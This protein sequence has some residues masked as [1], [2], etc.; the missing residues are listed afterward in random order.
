MQEFIEITD[1]DLND[2]SAST[3]NMVGDVFNQLLKTTKAKLVYPSSSKLPQQFIDKLYIDFKVLLDE[4]GDVRFKV[5]SDGILY[6]NQPV[7]KAR[8]K[9]ENFAH[10]FF[11][12][13]ILELEFRKGITEEELEKFVDILTMIMR[14][15]LVD[16]DL[17]TLLWEAGFEHFSYKL[18]D[19]SIDLETFEYGTGAL[20]TSIDPSPEN[21]K[22]IF[23]TSQDLDFTEEDFD[24]ESEKNN[25][26]K[27]P[28]G[29]KSLVNNVAEYINRITEYS[30]SEKAAINDIL[31]SDNEFNYRNYI[32]DIMFELLGMEDDNAGYRETLDLIGKVRDDFIRSG[33]MRS[34]TVIFKRS[35]ELHEAIEHLND[36]KAK[37]LGEFIHK[38]GASEKIRVIVDMLNTSKDIEY[39]LISEYVKLFTWHA[40]DPLIWALG[41]LNHYPAR[42]AICQG[43]EVIAVDNVEMLGKGTEN[44]RWY[45]VRNVVSV[46]G[47][48]GSPKALS[49]FKRTITHSDIRVRK[50]TVVS[51]AKI[52]GDQAAAFLIEALKDEN[53]NLQTLAL[54][55]L[56]K[57]KANKAFDYLKVMISDKNFKNR[58]VEQIREILEGFARLGGQ[59]AFE[60]LK[61]QVTRKTLFPSEKQDRVRVYATRALGYISIP[62][63]IRLLD[64][65]SKSRNKSMADAAKRAL[66]R[67]TRG[68][69]FV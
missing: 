6:N 61:N 10:P 66:L 14:S 62:Q 15:A 30:E 37:R 18:M 43:L 33:D 4:L 67:R 60:Q 23:D 1:S 34:A 52:G 56:V 35:I 38:F 3:K 21:Y 29:Y 7:Y 16:D 27:R 50:E 32:T 49:Y 25:P 57:Q 54:R 68:D 5:E 36:E 11:R 64:K 40:V 2:I 20:K 28:A 53:E 44:P 12:D 22:N 48:I 42:R 51:A 13:G 41:E 17:A 55:E 24:L 65:I 63:A 9:A 69:D 45:V 31:A 26:Q 8:N 46:L 39:D 58:P 19:D 47:K 59:N